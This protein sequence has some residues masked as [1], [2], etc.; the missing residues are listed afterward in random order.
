MASRR[1]VENYFRPFDIQYRDE[2]YEA[3]VSIRRLFR[4]KSHSRHLAG[5]CSRDNGM[6]ASGIRWSALREFML[7]R[8]SPL[9]IL[10]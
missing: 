8:L 4:K 3:R 1:T 7:S 2:K 5:S 10:R 9:T 6:D